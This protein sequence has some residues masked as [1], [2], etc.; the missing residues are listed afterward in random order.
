MVTSKSRTH[1][2]QRGK[3]KQRQIRQKRFQKLRIPIQS[4]GYRRLRR[5]SRKMLRREKAPYDVI[6]PWL[7]NDMGYK[8]TP[9]V[10]SQETHSAHILD[11]PTETL[12]EVLLHS[13]HT[14]WPKGALSSITETQTKILWKKIGVLSAVC[15]AFRL[16]MPYVSKT[17]M[18][19]NIEDPLRDRITKEPE[20]KIPE[21][22]IQ[23]GLSWKSKAVKG[24]EVE[25]PKKKTRANVARKKQR[26]QKCWYCEERHPIKDPVCPME[27]RDPV[28]WAKMTK[29]TKVMKMTNMKGF[30]EFAGT[31]VV[32]ED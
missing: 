16:A 7:R 13:V 8:Y 25:I 18:R 30:A 20:L 15:P 23:P 14:P 17:A 2:R 10:S 9:Y 19:L 3:R 11:L 12:Q 29:G 32:F 31:K 26:P 21:W 28:K 6:M 22:T 4:R 24:S 5:S 27:R 1:I